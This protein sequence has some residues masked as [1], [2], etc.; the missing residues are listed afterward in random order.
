METEEN[1]TKMESQSK[2][3]VE[4]LNE[5]NIEEELCESSSESS[6]TLTSTKD[7]KKKSLQT[8]LMI[9]LTKLMSQMMSKAKGRKKNK[10]RVGSTA[11]TEEMSD[12]PSMTN[13]EIVFNFLHGQETKNEQEPELEHEE[14]SQNQP[15]T[16]NMPPTEH[17]LPVQ[18]HNFQAINNRPLM[19]PDKYDG[20]SDW[21]DYLAHFESCVAINAW[22]DAEASKFLAA[23][24]RG[25]ALRLLKEQRGDNWTYKELKSKLANR[26]SPTKQAETYLLELR[27]RKR[28][29]K[30][31]LQELGRNIRELTTRAY[32]NFDAE[33]ID[34]LAKIHFTDALHNPDIRAGIFHAKAA[35][36]DETVQAAVNTETFLQTESQRGGWRKNVHNRTLRSENEH[37]PPMKELIENAVKEALEKLTEPVKQESVKKEANGGFRTNRSNQNRE[38]TKENRTCYYCNK[39]GHIAKDCHKK[40]ADMAR[41]SNFEQ[42]YPTSSGYR[43]WTEPLNEPRPPQGAVVRPNDRQ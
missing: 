25:Q 27:N 24:L 11:T 39:P 22:G 1:L 19:M 26:F 31:S 5:G 32:P 17:N 20:N 14:L 35:T 8:R 9:Q 21:K 6:A 10:R 36:L 15:K 29:P 42:N 38:R 12:I 30:E 33:G 18:Q 37:E 3:K 13:S 43:T 16:V 7:K 40:R 34:R 2:E 4:T 23:S 41:N 28:N